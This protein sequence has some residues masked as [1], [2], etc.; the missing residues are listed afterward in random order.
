MVFLQFSGAVISFLFAFAFMAVA[1]GGVH[2]ATAAVFFCT[3]AVMFAGA[4]ITMA[5]NKSRT[6]IVELLSK[7]NN[8]TQGDQ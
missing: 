7:P 1:K 3:G 2:E 8:S 6:T 4:S 5:I